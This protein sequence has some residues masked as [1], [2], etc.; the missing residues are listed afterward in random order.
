[1]FVV[2]DLEGPWSSVKPGGPLDALPAGLVHEVM[3]HPAQQAAIGEIARLIAHLRAAGTAQELM[4]FQAE[5]LAAAYEL[6]TRRAQCTWAIRRLG[7]R[8]LPPGNVEPPMIGDVTTID[9]WALERFVAERLFRQL[10]AV[11]DALAWR[12]FGFNRSVIAVLGSNPSP[13]GLV[14]TSDS[15]NPAVKGLL[16]ELQEITRIWD[17]TGH[18]VLFHDLTNCIRIGDATEVF[19][20]GEYR[21]H[22]FKTNSKNQSKIQKQRMS[23]AMSSLRGGGPL[24]DTDIWVVEVDAVHETRLD[25]LR[26]VLRLAGERG[27]QGARVGAGWSVIA[28]SSS[29]LHRRANSSDQGAAIMA[30]EQR[31][32]DRRAGIKNE[33]LVLSFQSHDSAARVPNQV[34]WAVYPIDPLD[35]A[36]LIVDYAGFRTS[37]AFDVLAEE[38]AKAGVDLHPNVE[39]VHAV[40]DRNQPVMTARLGARQLTMYPNQLA[41]LQAEFLTPRA[42]AAGVLELLRES[43]EARQV[44]IRYR[45]DDL[46]WVG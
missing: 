17:T 36:L 16:N 3:S 5:L 4:E 23:A 10:R 14:K 2:S 46:P 27:V 11:G 9:S 31:R 30:A 38:F 37:V 13:G 44:L 20:P 41:A 28:A 39:P 21:A 26:D 40:L 42:V 29:P 43:A 7:Q 35:A 45:G 33:G 25:S 12:T 22:E 15:S 19:S 24:P 32:V 6:D 34:P 1:M 8:K 18:F